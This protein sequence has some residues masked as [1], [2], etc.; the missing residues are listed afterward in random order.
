MQIDAFVAGKTV[1]SST[2]L[3]AMTK[4]FW[5]NAVFDPE[6]NLLI[7]GNTSPATRLPRY[8]THVPDPDWIAPQYAVGPQPAV[9]PQAKTLKRPGWLG[10]AWLT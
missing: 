5:P 6:R 4:W 9:K 2:I 3:Q 1:P 8:P 10:G 7:A